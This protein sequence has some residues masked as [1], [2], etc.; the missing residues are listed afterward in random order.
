M[1]PQNNQSKF[2]VPV[3]IVIAGVVIAGAIFLTKGMP[4]NVP[5]NTGGEEVS[6]ERELNIP[7]LSSADHVLGN[8]N[9]PVSIIEYSDLECPFSKT[10]Y[11]S[12][13]SVINSS[14]K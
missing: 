8:P 11:I 10:F 4:N 3:A 6:L 7:P 13:Q 9:A 14:G 5:A 1:E 12:M 2:S